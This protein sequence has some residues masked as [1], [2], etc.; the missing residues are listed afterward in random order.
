MCG[1]DCSIENVGIETVL[2]RL[3]KK[4]RFGLRSETTH[5]NPPIRLHKNWPEED[6]EDR[7]RDLTGRNVTSCR[8]RYCEEVRLD[9]KCCPQQMLRISFAFHSRDI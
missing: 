1:S 5:F 4:A 8:R 6:D 7:T 2:F 3:R 9:L